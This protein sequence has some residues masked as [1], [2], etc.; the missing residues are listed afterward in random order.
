[1]CAVC[2]AFIVPAASARYAPHSPV[3]WSSLQQLITEVFVLYIFHRL[4]VIA[5]CCRTLSSCS[6]SCTSVHYL[7]LRW[8][9]LKYKLLEIDTNSLPDCLNKIAYNVWSPR[10]IETRRQSSR[11][12]FWD[13][14]YCMYYYDHIILWYF[15]FLFA[16]HIVIVQFTKFININTWFVNWYFLRE[17]TFRIFS[18]VSYQITLSC[19]IFKL[20]IT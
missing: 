12:P 11:K 8:V 5:S 14:F 1:M 9:S 10:I 2:C 19:W 13:Y 4:G 18:F 7:L 6:Y 17:F 20:W 16:V 15:H 3:G